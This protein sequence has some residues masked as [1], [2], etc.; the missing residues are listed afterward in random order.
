MYQSGGSF[1][2]TSYVP[3]YYQKSLIDYYTAYY[4]GSDLHLFLE[5]NIPSN[6]SFFVYQN[7]G[8]W[9]LSVNGRLSSSIICTEDT[10]KL[11]KTRERY[12]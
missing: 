4:E 1:E 5:N 11:K 6:L 3:I 7:E 2:S 12:H 9:V 10:K 8:Q